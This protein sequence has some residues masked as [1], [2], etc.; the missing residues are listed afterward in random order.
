MLPNPKRR[1]KGLHQLLYLMAFTLSFA[2]TTSWAQQDQ[3]VISVDPQDAY[4][5]WRQGAVFIDV[6]PQAPK[7]QNLPEDTPWHDIPRAS[8]SGAVWVPN[9]GFATISDTY[10]AYFLQ[11]LSDATNGNL[12][13][14]I[15]LFCY[16]GCGM[17]HTAA[18]R[19]VTWGYLAVH[20]MPAGIE[21][22]AAAGF[23]VADVTLAPG[24]P[25]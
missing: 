4:T 8:I 20:W 24:Q 17:G 21:G 14:P 7:P 25:S 3:S 15:V 13:R 12:A 11:S 2:A 19:A 22:W 6:F 16:E 10:A 9:V 1:P 23:P 18:V 5:L